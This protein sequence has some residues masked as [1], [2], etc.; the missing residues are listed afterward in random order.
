MKIITGLPRTRTF[1]LS[2]YFSN[3]IFEPSLD[4]IK[5]DSFI[6]ASGINAL[7]PFES[8]KWKHLT[9][10]VVIHRNPQEVYESLLQYLPQSGLPLCNKMISPYALE[11]LIEWEKELL[12]LEGFH[13]AYKDI[14]NELKAICNYL[15]EPY[16]ELKHRR[17]KFENLQKFY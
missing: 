15:N 10:L 6:I 13:L 16:D 8:N 2:N 1:W 7:L 9:H 14:D 17:L 3:A 5:E 12:S 4:E 11:T